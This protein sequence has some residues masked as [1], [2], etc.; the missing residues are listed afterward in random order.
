MEATTEYQ[1]E[2]YRVI[3]RYAPKGLGR[4]NA[5]G[6]Y[7]KPIPCP[8]VSHSNDD[9]SPAAYLTSKGFIYCH[10]CGTSIPPREVARHYGIDLPSFTPAE[11][12]A[13]AETRQE[14]AKKEEQAQRERMARNQIEYNLARAWDG[15]DADVYFEFIDSGRFDAEV[16][17]QLD[18]WRQGVIHFDFGK[19]LDIPA[20]IIKEVL[21]TDQTE[22]VHQSMQIALRRTERIICAYAA[23]VD[24]TSGTA[25]EWY[26]AINWLHPVA[27]TSFY[28]NIK[29]APAFEKNGKEYILVA[30]DEFEA[31]LTDRLE[32]ALWRNK[33][34]GKL[35]IEDYDDLP[36]HNYELVKDRY[37]REDEVIARAAWNDFQEALEHYS[38]F[39]GRV[40]KI[41]Q[42][43]EDLD[44]AWARRNSYDGDKRNWEKRENLTGIERKR[45]ARIVKKAGGQCKSR[46]W[47]VDKSVAKSMAQ[48]RATVPDA[49]FAVKSKNKDGSLQGYIV[50]T[51][52]VIHWDIENSENV[53]VGP[54]LKH[55]R[56]LSEKQPMPK[57]K[58]RIPRPILPKIDITSPH[59]QRKEMQI[60]NLWEMAKRKGWVTNEEYDGIEITMDLM[61]DIFRNPPEKKKENKRDCPF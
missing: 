9:K 50:Q 23:R 32:K 36:E 40:W 18:L 5:K 52:T 56:T 3:E 45:Y 58:P 7:Q 4:L 44:V 22:G 59:S 61:L 24:R 20:D 12:R 53:A 10:K 16:E 51:P 15:E 30:Q 33:C 29:T 17:A 6:F 48:A 35:G 42:G 11:R 8:A 28:D 13:F 25:A 21:R 37:N 39:S 14:R 49:A 47:F 43:V 1:Q 38:D 46:R 26:E 34:R 57:P 55:T 60:V 27:Q 2:I 19:K 31:A 54:P 41:P